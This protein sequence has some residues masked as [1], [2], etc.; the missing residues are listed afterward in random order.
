MITRRQRL[1]FATEL[2]K[3]SIGKDGKVNESKVKMILNAID[4]KNIGFEKS[5]N[6]NILKLYLK[7]IKSRLIEESITITS[8]YK[9]SES[10][11]N[12]L[13]NRLGNS[14]IDFIENKGIIA[15]VKIQK[16][17]DI[18]DYSVK[19]KLDKLTS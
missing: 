4:S 15:G 8:S 16:G 6:I 3:A 17:W 7:L 14:D 9:L 2:E 18:L 1:K 5:E 12:Y 13:K 10:E 19:N 11:K